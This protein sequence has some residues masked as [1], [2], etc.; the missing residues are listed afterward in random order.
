MGRA[1]FGN[2]VYFP[3]FLRWL[4][5]TLVL[6]FI[7]PRAW[8]CPRNI[9][10]SHYSKH[11]DALPAESQP[12]LLDIGVGTGHFLEHAPLPTRSRVVLA[13]INDNP[14][15]EAKGRLRRAHA[16]VTVDTVLADVFELGDDR[17]VS[18]KRLSSL[19]G[20]IEQQHE[21]KFDVISCMLLLHCLPGNGRRKGEAVAR[22]HRI[23]KPGGVVVGSTVLGLGVKH[24]YFGK[25]LMFLY[26]L[27]G[28]FHNYDD[29]VDDI[30]GPLKAAFTKVEFRVVGTTLLFEA[31]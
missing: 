9:L 5:D 22:L 2:A 21:D 11:I 17:S 12:N 8:G 7:C 26:N 3:V 1:E 13:D 19:K 20:N 28:V 4:Y 14:L 30:I 16:D 29:G 23:L 10:Q 15:A 6:G 27:T 31:R 18:S 24:N 25:V